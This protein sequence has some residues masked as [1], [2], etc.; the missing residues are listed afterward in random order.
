MY[1]PRFFPFDGFRTASVPQDDATSRSTDV[2]ASSSSTLGIVGSRGTRPIHVKPE[3]GGRAARP[4]PST[5]P[6]HSVGQSR[7][8]LRR[9]RGDG[10]RVATRVSKNLGTPHHL[11]TAGNMTES[12]RLSSSNGV[13]RHLAH[14]L[15]SQP[16]I[17][18]VFTHD[19]VRL[20][21][22]AA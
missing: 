13:L 10:S 15:E 7:G 5:C 19:D 11:L 3:L 1:S 14:F 18:S 16:F 9:G 20:A 17:F 4:S 12:V 8:R 21:A 6:Y 22:H 2:E